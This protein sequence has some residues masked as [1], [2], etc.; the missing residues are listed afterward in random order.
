VYSR[1]KNSSIGFGG[2]TDM[3]TIICVGFFATGSSA[4][5][6][7]LREF[8]N[9]AQTKQGVECT[10]L[11]FPD[12]ISDMEFNI[13]DNPHRHNSGFALKRYEHYVKTFAHTYHIIFGSE[14]ERLSKEYIDSLTKFEFQ[15]YWAGDT[16]Y[17]T[18]LETLYYYFCRAV[19]KLMPKRFKVPSTYNY[20]P[21]RKTKF[22]DATESEFLE[23]TQTYVQKLLKIINK[24]EKEY[25]VLDQAVS[26]MNINRYLRYF[27]GDAK[28]IV[29]DRDPRDVYIQEIILKGKVV[30]K[31]VREFIDVYKHDRQKKYSSEDPSK[32]L[33]VNFE[34]LIYKYDETTAK[35]DSFLGLNEKN[36]SEHKK[37]FDPAV[38]IKNTKLWEKHKE[39]SEQVAIIEKEI[40]DYL[41]HYE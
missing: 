19:N 21:K 5:D 7:Y 12:G 39:F 36:R 16:L 40:P 41:Y 9:I 25:V 26:A 33:C 27:V 1:A 10:F 14:W 11:Q 28:V 18:K 31:D 34:D 38:S 35:I 15:G 3:K 30:P 2:M 20:F 13:V 29:V 24:N 4:V 6:D 22:C 8:D 32:V 17:Q 37:Y 23:K